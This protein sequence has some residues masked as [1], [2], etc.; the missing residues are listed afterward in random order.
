MDTNKNRSEFS[1]DSKE[2][3]NKL[4]INQMTDMGR[5][6]QPVNITSKIVSSVANEA[7]EHNRSGAHGPSDRMQSTETPLQGISAHHQDIFNAQD[8]FTPALLRLQQENQDISD[9]IF[10]QMR[11]SK[12]G[13]LPALENV[14]NVN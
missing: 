10:S 3:L 6:S 4:K 9:V 13:G 7:E 2:E 11:V 14:Q 1:Q 8:G 5:H 12:D